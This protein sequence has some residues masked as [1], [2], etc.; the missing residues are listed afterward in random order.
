[1]NYTKIKNEIEREMKE[2]SERTREQESI[3]SYHN[4][5]SELNIEVND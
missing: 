4:I 2:E 1:M 5:M 3:Q